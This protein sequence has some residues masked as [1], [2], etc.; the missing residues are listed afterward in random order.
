MLRWIAIGNIMAWTQGGHDESDRS[1]FWP[2]N[3]STE[4]NRTEQHSSHHSGKT[5][6][7][8]RFPL[9]T[10]LSLHLNILENCSL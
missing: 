1:R 6:L 5:E 7:E 10:L 8:N 3:N 2:G 4:Q 9:L